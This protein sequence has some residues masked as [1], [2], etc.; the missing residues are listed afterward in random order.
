MHVIARVTVILSFGWM[1]FWIVWGGSESGKNWYLSQLSQTLSNEDAKGALPLLVLA[2]PILLSGAVSS[3]CLVLER[4]FLSKKNVRVPALPHQFP[5]WIHQCFQVLYKGGFCMGDGDPVTLFLVFILIPLAIYVASFIQQHWTFDD[6]DENIMGVA[7]SF[8]F[9]ALIACNL[10]TIPVARYSSLLQLVGWSHVR[11]IFF[12]RWI[13]RLIVFASLAHGT[14]HSYR[15]ISIA[16]ESF[17]KMVTI[18]NGCWSDWD[19]Y[20]PICSSPDTDC[21]CYDHFRNLTGCLAVIPLLLILVSSLGTVRRKFY[22]MFWRIH[23]IS[24]PLA[25]LFVIVH[26]P[27]AILY[28]CGGLL[29]YL[30]SSMPVFLETRTSKSEVAL[31]SAKLI[32]N[33]TK[34]DDTVPRTCVSL[35][36][37]VSSLA[38]ERYRAAQYVRLWASDIASEAHPFTINKVW[39]SQEDENYM[40]I[41]FRQT[42]NFTK[43][44]GHRL[45]DSQDPPVIHLDGFHGPL[46]RL[47]ILSKHDVVLIVAGGIGVTP[48]LSLLR[49]LYDYSSQKSPALAARNVIHLNW[50]CREVALIDYVRKE[51]L[52]EIAG[53]TT[54]DHEIRITIYYTGNQTPGVERHEASALSVRSPDYM[55]QFQNSDTAQPFVPSKFA[56]GSKSSYRD[57]LPMLISMILI[58][59]VGLVITWTCYRNWSVGYLVVWIPLLVFSGLVAWLV[60]AIADNDEVLS[61]IRRNS[62]YHGLG[63]LPPTSTSEAELPEISQQDSAGLHLEND[64]ETNKRNHLDKSGS[65]EDGRPLIEIVEGRPDVADLLNH[66]VLDDA[67]LPAVYGCG[68]AGMMRN[69]RVAVKCRQLLRVGRCRGRVALYE[70]LFEM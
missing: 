49:E 14:L 29:Y 67:L 64:I 37:K 2:F 5:Q 53:I 26:W 42:G 51:Y 33:E 30:A 31:V 27:R 18:P 25:F 10:L 22:F 9:G 11:A 70:E 1:G 57:N 56:V 39:S 52:D 61:T 19:G 62:S 47:D 32:D 69:L 60:N 68:P 66:A 55:Q 23:V 7:N 46:D 13:G 34:D 12:H 15:W 16:N 58:G 6:V 40:R 4:P 36:L 43:Q 45:L 63:E 41:I 54:G 21:S 50:T 24:G 17:F 44:L 3:F 20:Q 38:M 65:R 8:A 35:T 59:G 28:I 48:Y